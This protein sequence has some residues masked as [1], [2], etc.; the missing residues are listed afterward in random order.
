[1]FRQVIYLPHRRSMNSSIVLPGSQCPYYICTDACMYIPVCIVLYICV[2]GCAFAYLHVIIVIKKSLNVDLAS[3][4]PP[5]INWLSI[6]T[7]M[8]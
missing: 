8:I 3:I 6:T 5:P 4:L 2:A 1:M 7:R